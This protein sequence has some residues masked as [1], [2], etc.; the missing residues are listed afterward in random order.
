M[1]RN[2]FQFIKQRTLAGDLR[3]STLS[4]QQ[5]ADW[6]TEWRRPGTVPYLTLKGAIALPNSE[7]TGRVKTVYIA[8]LAPLE[9]GPAFPGIYIVLQCQQRNT[10]NGSAY[11]TLTLGDRTGQI[12]ARMWDN[13]PPSGMIQK[14][15]IVRA[16]AEVCRFDGRL[17]LKV[18]ELRRAAEVE[19]DRSDLLPS[20][21]Q[22]IGALWTT[23]CGY[24]DSFRD[25]HLKSLLQSVLEDTA[26]ARALK[27]AP[28]AKAMHHAWLGGLLEHIVSLLGLADSVATHYREIHR[29]LLLTGVILHDI[30]KLRELSWKSGFDYTI[31]GQLLGHIQIGIGIVTRKMDQLPDFP[32]RLKT[33]V[34]HL[35]LSHHG[36]LEFGSPKL[37]MIPEAVML[38]YLDDL[39]AKM[40]TMRSEFE[41]AQ[42]A[43]RESG[44]F[45]EWVRAMERPLLHTSE[46]L[47]CGEAIPLVDPDAEAEPEP[48]QTELPGLRG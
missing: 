23:L 5:R 24:V 10:K 2:S 25:P 30:G 12:E 39:D 16:H 42:Q 48:E 31:E 29:D 8:D 37:P 45:T 47:G 40:Q 43:N 32:S 28:A 27:E 46:Y 11:L 26:I 14:G 15:D 33:L 18:E 34:L 21:T 35:I 44:Q 36:K 3:L 22:D 9:N 38:H 4:R 13:L 1:S 41:K 17:Q 19:F 6:V 7:D 20:T